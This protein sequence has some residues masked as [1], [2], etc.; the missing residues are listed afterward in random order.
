MP[1]ASCASAVDGD[2]RSQ[3]HVV[4]LGIR[5]ILAGSTQTRPS[6]PRPLAL[7]KASTAPGRRSAR[8]RAVDDR[9]PFF[10]LASVF[11]FTTPVVCGVSPTC[12]VR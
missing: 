6:P 5:R 9:T 10:I 12:S 7:F 11:A 2:V 3:N 1:T 8:P 4:Q